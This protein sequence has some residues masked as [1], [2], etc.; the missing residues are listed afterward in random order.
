M[1]NFFINFDEFVRLS[2]LILE[3][4]KGDGARYDSIL[5]PLKGGFYL[6]DFLSRRL[7]IP[8]NYLQISSY[9]GNEK[10]EYFIR[11]IP[12]IDHETALICDDI[13]DTGGTI[14]RIGEIFPLVKFD[15]ACLVTKERD[16]PV[17]Y[18]TYVDRDTW[19]DFFWE[20]M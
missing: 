19:V 16:V 14:R 2:Y 4:I 1:E 15:A 8:V 11:C 6:S 3:K 18:G 5:C 10:C 20:K 13:Y 12:E 7:E 9:R 17:F